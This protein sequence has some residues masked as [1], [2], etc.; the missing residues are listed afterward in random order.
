V[1]ATLPAYALRK[2]GEPPWPEGTLIVCSDGLARYTVKGGRYVP[3]E[4]PVR[5]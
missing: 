2:R 3:L 5:A 4:P 1:T